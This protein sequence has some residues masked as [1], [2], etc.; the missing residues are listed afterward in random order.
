MFSDSSF[1]KRS[2]WMSFTWSTWCCRYRPEFSAGGTV[3]LPEPL[4]NRRVT[5][6]LSWARFSALYVFYYDSGLTLK[7]LAPLI[8]VCHPVSRFNGRI[9][10]RIHPSRPRQAIESHKSDSLVALLIIDRYRVELL[11]SPYVRQKNKIQ[12]N[13]VAT[14]SDSFID[15]VFR[16][17]RK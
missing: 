6:D 9:C 4:Q 13:S 11:I 3:Q 12:R 2:T 14:P 7:F 16:Y 1:A 10:G 17:K 5:A 15:S 8:C